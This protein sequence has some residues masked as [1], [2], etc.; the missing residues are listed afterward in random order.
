MKYVAASVYG[1]AAYELP[2]GYNG[3]TCGTTVVVSV[4][5][6]SYYRHISHTNHDKILVIMPI[7]MI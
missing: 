6:S 7:N 4:Q 3:S 5:F 1:D 2:S